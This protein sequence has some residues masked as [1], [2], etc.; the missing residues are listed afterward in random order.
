[1]M[2]LLFIQTIGRTT[3]KA[4]MRSLKFNRIGL[5]VT[6]S[7]LIA[8]T[9]CGNALA[10]K[11]PVAGVSASADDGNVPANTLDGSLATRWSA[12][13]DGQWIRYDLGSSK[14]VGSLKIAWYQGDQRT[15]SFDVQ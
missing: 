1:M 6:L 15:S 8:T 14:T 11:L 5:V 3:G 13:G 2:T 9:W 4:G 7:A 10:D 12:S